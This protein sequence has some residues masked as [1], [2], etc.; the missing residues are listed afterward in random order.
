MPN[1]DWDFDSEMHDIALEGNHAEQRSVSGRFLRGSEIA[2]HLEN[3]ARRMGL[4][5]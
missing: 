1:V 2:H 5:S 3:E 4:G